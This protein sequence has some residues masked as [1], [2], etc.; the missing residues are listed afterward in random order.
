MVL[1]I[2]RI[3]YIEHVKKA[4]AK[5]TCLE[6]FCFFFSYTNI[7]TNKNVNYGTGMLCCVVCV[8]V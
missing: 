5:I 3:I 7:L 6:T 4:F 1:N 8:C 2:M